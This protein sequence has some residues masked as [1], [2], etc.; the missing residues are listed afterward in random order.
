M[1]AEK[2]FVFCTVSKLNFDAFLTL[3]PA[4]I[5]KLGQEE[6]PRSQWRRM[7]EHEKYRAAFD[8][9]SNN[10]T[11]EESLRATNFHSFLAALNSRVG[12][13]FTQLS[14]LNK[15]I[16]ATLKDLTFEKGIAKE[17]K[18]AYDK[19]TML[20]VQQTP[21]IYCANF[22]DAFGP[23]FDKSVNRFKKEMNIYCLQ[24]VFDQLIEHFDF[25]INMEAEVAKVSRC[26][27]YLVATQIRWVLKHADKKD[28][29]SEFLNTTFYQ[30]D[31]K[32]SQWIL[33]LPK[34]IQCTMDSD[35]CGGH[36]HCEPMKDCVKVM[37]SMDIGT[38][39]SPTGKTVRGIERK[40]FHDPPKDLPHH[41]IQLSSD[42]MWQ[43]THTKKIVHGKHNPA[44]GE[45]G[46][47]Q[48]SPLD[49]YTIANSILLHSHEKNFY[50]TFGPEKISL[51][52][53][54]SQYSSL[55]ERLDHAVVLPT[56]YSSIRKTNSHGAN[57]TSLV[58][59]EYARHV[60]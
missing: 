44:I 35:H 18:A 4:F 30:W 5:E 19:S 15:Q 43:N 58:L 32:Q 34:C 57:R 9:I 38:W 16:N 46:W 1:S 17:C 27:T 26:L 55:T 53:I 20:G 51:E 23:C 28:R 47:D 24:E 48:L 29:L 11:L 42:E 45:L 13:S 25:V 12:G 14:L 41:W 36:K 6:I 33:S 2:A 52:K 50:K 39:R 10:D 49:F 37:E 59:R 60:Q 40:F 22:W 56:G 3:D 8:A 31:E 7:T 21:L 54:V